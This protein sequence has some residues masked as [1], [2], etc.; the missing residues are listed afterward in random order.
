MSSITPRSLA[1]LAADLGRSLGL[2]TSGRLAAP[3]PVLPGEALPPEPLA[4]AGPAPELP[5]IRPPAT[6]EALRADAAAFE[7]EALQGL[8]ALATIPALA[9]SAVDIR[10]MARQL[11][12]RADELRAVAA[13]REAQA[14]Q[15]RPATAADLPP[16]A[17]PEWMLAPWAGQPLPP[18]KAWHP[19][20]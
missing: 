19:A 2:A 20:A 9:R 8:Q 13:S 1:P 17:R 6:P 3:R 7:A 18:M 10:S 12:W 11:I 16:A 14:W 5:T 4:Q 15:A